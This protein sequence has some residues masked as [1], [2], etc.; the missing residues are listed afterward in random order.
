MF[1]ILHQIFTAL[2]FLQILMLDKDQKYWLFLSLQV[3]L[4]FTAYRGSRELSNIV[5]HP[6]P[7]DDL[8]C[9]N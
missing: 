2:K 4:T 7:F 1:S 9:K 6:P 3:R 5:L 8:H